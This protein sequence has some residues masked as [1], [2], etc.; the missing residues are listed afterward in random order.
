MGYRLAGCIALL[1][2]TSGCKRETDVTISE[3][4]TA[5]TFK[6]VR[7]GKPICVDDVAIYKAD[8]QLNPLW[9]IGAPAGAKCRSEFR[10]GEAPADFVASGAP[11]KLIAG[12]AYIVTMRGAGTV[13]QGEFTK[14]F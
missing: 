10:Y 6:A 12:H 1:V 14:R 9:S 2:M 13:G 4:P 11:T 3:S 7:G 5:L 8:D